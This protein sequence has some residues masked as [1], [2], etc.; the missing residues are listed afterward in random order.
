MAFGRQEAIIHWKK[1]SECDGGEPG[2][3]GTRSWGWVGLAAQL[4]CRNRDSG[5]TCQGCLQAVLTPSEAGESNNTGLFVLEEVRLYGGGKVGWSVKSAR[6][7][8]DT[9]RTG[10][11]PGKIKWLVNLCFY[12]TVKIPGMDLGCFC[13]HAGLFSFITICKL[14]LFLSCPQIILVIS[15]VMRFLQVDY[16]YLFPSLELVILI[17]RYTFRILCASSVLIGS[18][19]HFL[20]QCVLLFFFFPCLI[21]RFELFLLWL[22]LK[23]KW[24]KV[25]CSIVTVWSMAGYLSCRGELFSHT[26]TDSAES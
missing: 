3:L 17:I 5:R 11:W 19:L 8:S 18:H 4:S 25:A 7:A 26:Q 12:S 10:R 2:W 22:W 14:K 16:I 21:L 24:G 13:C 1:G 15:I 23:V 9:E 6:F 20:F